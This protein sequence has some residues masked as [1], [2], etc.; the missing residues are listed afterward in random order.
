MYCVEVYRELISELDAV[1]SKVCGVNLNV[2]ILQCIS[3]KL[4][5]QSANSMLIV[6]ASDFDRTNYSPADVT[7]IVVLGYVDQSGYQRCEYKN[8]HGNRRDKLDC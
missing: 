6:F 2:Q 1:T 4:I 7:G 3:A 5:C 8:Q